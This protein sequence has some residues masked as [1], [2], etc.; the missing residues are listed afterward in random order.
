LQTSNQL[1]SGLQ[2]AYSVAPNTANRL[3]PMIVQSAERYDVSPTLLAALIR[4]ESNYNS[5]ALSYR[6]DWF[7]SNYFELLA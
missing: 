3:S 6:C 1:S 7:N 5:S 4:Q 2:N